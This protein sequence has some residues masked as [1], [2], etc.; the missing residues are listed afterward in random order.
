MKRIFTLLLALLVVSGAALPAFAGEKNSYLA[1]E[2]SL[3]A[4]PSL[5]ISTG[6]KAKQLV[7]KWSAVPRADGYEVFRSTSGKSGSYQ[8]IADEGGT[9]YTDTGLKNSTAYYYAVR[10]YAWTGERTV[11]S[12]MKKANLSTRITKT[13]AADRFVK[14]WK[15]MDRFT[16]AFRSGEDAIQKTRSGWYGYYFPFTLKGCSTKAD[17]VK[18]LRAYFTKAAAKRIANFYLKEIGGKLYIWLPEDPGSIGTLVINDVT[19]RKISYADKRAICKFGTWF[20]PLFGAEETDP[21][22]YVAVRFTLDYESGNWRFD[23]DGWYNFDFSYTSLI[24]PNDGK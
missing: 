9:T 22:E 12:P 20:V 3:A 11:Y 13:F 6:G 14:T 1:G 17:A 2:T 18:F 21:L 23:D 8:P 19:T 16:N 24:T 7:L 5:K 15:A 10:A 4:I